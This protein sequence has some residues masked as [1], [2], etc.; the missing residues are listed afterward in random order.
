[1]LFPTFAC[2]ARDVKVFGKNVGK[3]KVEDFINKAFQKFH[4]AICFCMKLED[5]LPMLM[6]ESFLN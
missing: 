2:S 1:V 3:T 4:I 6:P 5:V